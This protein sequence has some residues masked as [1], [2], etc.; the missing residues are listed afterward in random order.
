MKY[1]IIFY[2]FVLSALSG[3][4]VFAQDFEHM[5]EGAISCDQ[6][7]EDEYKILDM[8]LLESSR[9]GPQNSPIVEEYGIFYNLIQM[10]SG[11]E[12][13]TKLKLFAAENGI[14]GVVIVPDQEAGFDGVIARLMQTTENKI[15]L[16]V[17]ENVTQDPVKIVKV[18]MGVTES[19]EVR[20]QELRTVVQVGEN[21][22]GWR[23][24]LAKAVNKGITK[25]T[26]GTPGT[27]I[28]FKKIKLE[29][30][31]SL[32]ELFGGEKI[33]LMIKN[34]GPYAIEIN[35]LDT[36]I[37]SVRNITAGL[38]SK[39]LFKNENVPY[40]ETLYIGDDGELYS[41]RFM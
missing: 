27:I 23:A 12:I 20:N 38:A 4:V 31:G 41:C 33:T 32:A 36:V 7:A 18:L 29:Q 37:S 13:P 1:K 2:L 40:P 39:I 6:L 19:Q 26:G 35:E 21:D 24:G 5:T 14:N 28:D 16:I 9:N 15:V 22:K 10:P 3:S 30:S 25:L 11:Y 17:T 34:Q 8:S